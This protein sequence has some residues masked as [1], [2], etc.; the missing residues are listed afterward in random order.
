MISMGY[1]LA[2]AKHDEIATLEDALSLQKITDLLQSGGVR[3]LNDITDLC[4]E[5][6]SA[7]V[8]KQI[9]T[10][11]SRELRQWAELMFTC[12][13]AQRS[14]GDGDI[15]FITQLV[16]MNAVEATAEPEIES[17]REVEV[18]DINSMVG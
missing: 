11:A 15:N 14:G 12:V 13:Q 1:S 17:P 8:K 2:M 4:S 6:M 7:V 18:I 9:T 5:M 3:E 10:G 16:Q